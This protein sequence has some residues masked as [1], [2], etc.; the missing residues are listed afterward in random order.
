MAIDLAKRSV[1]AVYPVG[2]WWKENPSHDRYGQ[3][4]RY[5]LIASIRALS[6]EV[7]I[8]TPVVNQVAASIEIS[9]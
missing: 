6:C 7:D 5:S 8:Y 2:G 3:K 9:T 1:I 4:V